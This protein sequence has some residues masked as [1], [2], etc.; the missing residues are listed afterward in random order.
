MDDID[1]VVRLKPQLGIIDTKSEVPRASRAVNAKQPP[2]PVAG[3][4]ARQHKVS[5]VD[6]LVRQLR[7]FERINEKG[8]QFLFQR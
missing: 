3:P 2:E 4:D 1:A 8:R 7:A 6:R 5:V